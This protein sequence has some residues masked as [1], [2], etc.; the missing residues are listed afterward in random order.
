MGMHRS[1]KHVFHLVAL[2]KDALAVPDFWYATELAAAVAAFER[3]HVDR[4]MA[5][6]GA[7]WRHT[8]AFIW[9]CKTSSQ[10]FEYHLINLQYCRDHSTVSNHQQLNPPTHKHINYL[11][12]YK[13]WPYIHTPKAGSAKKRFYGIYKH[14]TYSHTK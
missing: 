11:C 10:H 12:V 8:S 5:A 6:S 14:P 2:N 13:L 7:E 9:S 3:V 4:N 1:A